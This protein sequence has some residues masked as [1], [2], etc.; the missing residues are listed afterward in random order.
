MNR[1]LIKKQAKASLKGKWGRAIGLCLVG[2]ILMMIVPVIFY[3]IGI[4]NSTTKQVA[5]STQVTSTSFVGAIFFILA[6]VAFVIIVPLF[7]YGMTKAF[8]ASNRGGD[9]KVG[10]VFD[11][12]KEKPGKTLGTG[13]LSAIIIFFCYFIPAAIGGYFLGSVI[14]RIQAIANAVANMD[15]G[16]V[17]FVIKNTFPR[18]SVAALFFIAAIVIGTI[19]T[20]MY[21]MIYYVRVDNPD[22]SVVQILKKSRKIMHGHKIDLF[23]LMFTFIGWHIVCNIT[24]GIGYLWLVPYMAAAEAAFYDQ[25]KA[26][27]ID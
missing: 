25:A 11:G 19:V 2:V 15:H 4:A 14:A 17:I 5:G 24:C 3:A 10:D 6:M 1:L 20:Y 13:I 21:K 16:R 27:M 22:D 23:V 26:D 8:M 9:F 12:F 7:V 18:L